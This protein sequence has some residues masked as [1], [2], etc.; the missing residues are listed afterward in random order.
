MTPN[1]INYML[2][3][4]K[5]F[6]A[7]V[8][9]VQSAVKKFPT[10]KH[11]LLAF[12]EEVGELAKAL[13]DHDRGEAK[14]KDVYAE[15]VQVA[16]MAARVRLEG[17]EAS[18]FKC[19]KPTDVRYSNELERFALTS[20]VKAGEHAENYDSNVFLARELFKQV[21]ELEALVL[22]LDE[23]DEERDWTWPEMIEQAVEVA[24]WACRVALEGDSTVS[25]AHAGK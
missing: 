21:G 3:V 15:A 14:P 18:K 8:K 2:E 5:F 19:W 4:R 1:D 11:Q 13:I 9:E 17:D 23:E 25:N 10:N 22:N 6:G 16:A 12:Q 24:A 7:V 20:A